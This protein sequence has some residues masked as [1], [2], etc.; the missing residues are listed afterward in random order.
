MIICWS[1]AARADLDRLHDFLAEYSFEIADAALDLLIEAPKALLD[2]PRRGSRLTDFEPREVR[3]LR[4][5]T[6]LLRYE[7]R[8]EEILIVRIFHARENRS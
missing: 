6:Y 8:A 4:V 7:L 5:G 1:P 3:E 2:F